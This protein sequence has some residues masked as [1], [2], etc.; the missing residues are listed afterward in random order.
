LLVGQSYGIPESEDHMLHVDLGS[1]FFTAV[2]WLGAPG[3]SLHLPGAWLICFPP[4][5]GC[6]G[7]QEA[8]PLRKR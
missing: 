6:G 8:V 5:P 2:Y 7:G 1:Y 4:P 3:G